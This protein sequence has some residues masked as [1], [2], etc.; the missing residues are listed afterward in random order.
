VM[1]RL[2]ERLVAADVV[3]AMR[4]QGITTD[5]RGQVLRLSPGVMTTEAGTERLIAAL[6][7]LV[8]VR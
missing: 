1:L 8:R 7:G 2:P 5:A 6:G 4:G 3:G